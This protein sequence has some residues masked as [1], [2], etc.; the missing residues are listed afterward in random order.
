MIRQRFGQNLETDEKNDAE[1]IKL[2]SVKNEHEIRKIIR[3]ESRT[4]IF[5]LCLAFFS[6]WLIFIGFIGFMISLKIF[7]NSINVRFRKT[8][9]TSRNLFLLINFVLF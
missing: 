6:V 1:K 8:F 9:Y 2:L 7:D 3:E 5:L 4:W